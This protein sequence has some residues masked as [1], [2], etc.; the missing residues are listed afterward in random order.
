MAIAS[1]RFFHS[2]SAQ[3]AAAIAPVRRTSRSLV[4]ANARARGPQVP[5]EA[6]RT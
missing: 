6:R 2:A 5:T 1:L 4:M 3:P